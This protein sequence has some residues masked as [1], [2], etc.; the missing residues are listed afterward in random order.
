MVQS[1]AHCGGC[2]N[3][4]VGQCGCDIY[5]KIAVVGAVDI[6]MLFWAPTVAGEEA[7]LCLKS[8]PPT[9]RLEK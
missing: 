7:R 4:N 3:E 2:P 8:L 1:N 9:R 5:L 6:V